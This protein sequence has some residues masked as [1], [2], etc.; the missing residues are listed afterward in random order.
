MTY[1][2]RAE[3]WRFACYV[4][5]TMSQLG[6]KK[7]KEAVPGAVAEKPA[8]GW[9]FFPV[10]GLEVASDEE[11]FDPP[12]FGDAT[13]CSHAM[14]IKRISAGGYEI[15]PIMTHRPFAEVA[16]ELLASVGLPRNQLFELQP[17]SYVAV[18][19]RT[20]PN[21]TKRRADLVRS[22]FSAGLAL[23]GRNIRAFGDDPR[24]IVWNL[25]PLN[26]S[27][28]PGKP[29]QNQFRPILNEHVVINPIQV[30]LSDVR[31]SWTNGTALR[32]RE[33]GEWDI[34]RDRPVFRLLGE[35]RKGDRQEKLADAALHLCRTACE[36][37]YSAQMQM[38]VTGIERLLYTSD[39]RQIRER[40]RGFLPTTERERLETVIAARNAFVH[41]GRLRDD[42][43]MKDLARL[44]LITGWVLLDFA[45]GYLERFATAEQY[46]KSHDPAVLG[47][48]FSVRDDLPVP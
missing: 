27:V 30:T 4:L 25:A 32:T 40:V 39:N 42:E 47:L 41:E 18:R 33:G 20:D 13:I 24:H 6:A 35:Q 48:I 38:A 19:P 16:P 8:P 9:T 12:I 44:A 22:I 31:S 17:P 2:H 46:V 43:E 37:S 14:A 15:H 23:R 28:S 34:G 5:A 11:A 36:P 45:V 29:P 10:Y 7:K 3:G 26:L 1:R 21:A